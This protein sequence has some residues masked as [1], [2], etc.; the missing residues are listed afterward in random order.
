MTQAAKA[1]GVNRVELV[2]EPQCAA[3]Y[4]TSRFEEPI[5]LEQGECLVVADLGGGT[6]DVSL[7]L[8]VTL[9]R[10]SDGRFSL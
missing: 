6:A 5:R 1:A 2:F 3:A 8:S 4:A 7:N 9:S 10:K